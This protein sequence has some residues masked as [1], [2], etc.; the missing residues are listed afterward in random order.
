MPA[1]K[2]ANIGARR[3]ITGDPYRGSIV[4]L[5]RSNLKKSKNGCK[6]GGP[7]RNCTL[8][9]IFLSNHEMN[10]PVIAEKSKPGKTRK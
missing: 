8:A 5:T 6:T 4:S 1:P 9:V 7:C 10:A 3:N 2:T